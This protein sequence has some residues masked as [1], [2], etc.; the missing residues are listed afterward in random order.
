MEIEFGIGSEIEFGIGSE[1]EFG[2]EFEVRDLGFENPGTIL[3]IPGSMS[4]KKSRALADA[5]FS[6]E[7]GI[8]SRNHMSMPPGIGGGGVSFFG[9]S[10]TAASIVKMSPAMDAAFC[11]A[12]RVTLVGSSTPSR[13]MLP[14]FPVWAL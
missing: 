4:A 5:G 2:I 9:I 7:N 12:D 6:G 1:I 11:S 3:G 8:P 14:Y 13:T 10:A